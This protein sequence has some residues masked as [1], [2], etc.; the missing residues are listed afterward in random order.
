MPEISVP[1]KWILAGEHAVIRGRPAVVFPLPSRTLKLSYELADAAA[2]SC[3]VEKSSPDRLTAALERV[4]PQAVSRLPRKPPAQQVTL[5]VTSNIPVS[6][7]L[8]SS[9]ALCASVG[10]LFVALGALDESDLHSYCTHLEDIFHGT[11]SGLDLAAVL[12][13]QPLKFQK[14]RPPALLPLAWK[15]RFYLSDTGAR[16]S[17]S[18]CIAKVR[19]H[20][21]LAEW[22]E[23]MGEAV[24]L[25]IYGLGE[26][27]KTGIAMLT[28]AIREA[29]ECFQTWGLIDG[30]TAK[31]L[32][33][34]EAAGAL[35][36]KPTGSGN[37]GFVL[38]LWNKEPPAELQALSV[39]A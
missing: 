7:G 2:F 35:A 33:T 21:Q 37:G 18:D 31:T 10:R 3:T 16:S 30:A 36:A 20:P 15:P 24:R 23:R 34:L 8:G 9:A 39:W 26:E 12:S 25:A 6:A 5:R 4:L 27:E 22:D 11:S 32:K 28:A 38:S 14:M 17:T 19:A 29:K 1:G 13:G